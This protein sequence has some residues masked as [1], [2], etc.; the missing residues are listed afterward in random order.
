M[1]KAERLMAAEHLAEAWSRADNGEMTLCLA[2]VDRALAII[3]PNTDPASTPSGVGRR[4]VCRTDA[5]RW[6]PSVAS[7][8]RS[9]GVAS[10]YAVLEAIRR[11]GT[12]QGVFLRFEDTPEEE[13]P[14]MTQREQPVRFNG[15]E[16]PSIKT[17]ALSLNDGRS[18]K[19]RFEHVRRH[20]ERVG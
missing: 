13:C 17:A 12:C 7:A 10:R 16:Y 4:V 9:L 2:A 6:W 14:P 1:T 19:S 8:A 18:Y 3:R 5:R 20:G 15:K 11:G